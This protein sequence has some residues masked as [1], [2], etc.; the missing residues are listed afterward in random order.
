MAD[1]TLPDSESV[2]QLRELLAKA[3]LGPW[4]FALLEEEDGGQPGM[5]RIY[6]DADDSVEATL[7]QLWSGEHDNAANAALIA[8]L[9]NAA[10][11]LLDALEAQSARI[12]ELEREVRH[13][14]DD[15]AHDHDA[16][17]AGKDAYLAQSARIAKLEE[18]LKEI[19]AYSGGYYPDDGEWDGGYGAGWEDA[20]DVAR[21][22]LTETK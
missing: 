22:A 7:A 19:V 1:K 6:T 2:R 5:W 9:R 10:P 21:R 3:T 11:A 18:A 20:A 12:A 17:R 14:Y 8:A 13:L 4:E 15:M 16:I